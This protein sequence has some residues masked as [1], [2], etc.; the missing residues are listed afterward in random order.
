[1]FGNTHKWVVGEFPV[2]PEF[3]EYAERDWFVF[4]NLDGDATFQSLN[5]D[6]P[7][8]VLAVF[9]TT[10]QYK[11]GRWAFDGKIVPID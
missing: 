10:V 5:A 6:R 4:V 2:S 11:R 7:M 1:M 8:A 3:R 9:G